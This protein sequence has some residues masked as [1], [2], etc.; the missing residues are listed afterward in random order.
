MELYSFVHSTEISIQCLRQFQLKDFT[1]LNLK[2]SFNIVEGWSERGK[3]VFASRE[4][5]HLIKKGA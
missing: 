1:A 5:K 4:V 3:V 2:D